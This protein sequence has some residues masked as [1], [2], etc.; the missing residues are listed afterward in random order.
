[1]PRYFTFS[2]NFKSFPKSLIGDKSILV[3]LRVNLISCDLSRFTVSPVLMHHFST[4]RRVLFM[5]E[6]KVIVEIPLMSKA[7]SSA[8]ATTCMPRPWRMVMSFF[9]T[10]FQYIGE[11]TPPWGA[12]SDWLDILMFSS[13]A[14]WGSFISRARNSVAEHKVNYIFDDRSNFPFICSFKDSFDRC[15]VENAACTYEDSKA[16]FFMF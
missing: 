12:S 2:A 7:R 4:S 13:V 15:V 8:Y 1:M 10:I 11:P 16:C 3:F 6:H 9:M 5:M 14:P